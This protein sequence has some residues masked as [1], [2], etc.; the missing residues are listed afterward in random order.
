MAACGRANALGRATHF[1]HFVKSGGR[2]LL[3]DRATTG[4]GG[5][6][7]ITTILLAVQLATGA[8]AFPL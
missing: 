4:L 2:T 3:S 5:L 1:S 7:V 8:G 6:I